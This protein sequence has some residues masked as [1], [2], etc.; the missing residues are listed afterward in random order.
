MASEPTFR[1]RR[2]GWVQ[3]LFLKLP[4]LVYR[5]PLA[6]LLRWRCVMVLTTIGRRSGR[7]R[8]TGISFMPVGERLIV[9][10][11]W[12]VSSNW[13]QNVRAN[14]EVVVQVGRRRM[15]GTARLVE[16]PLQRA[17][18]MLRM[19]ARSGACGPPKLMRP[20][21]T[22]TRVFDYEA[23]IRMAVAQGGDLPVV[24]ITPHT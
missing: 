13:Y 5:G 24:E 17:E 18:L 9:F 16:D 22:L 23:D 12:G 2:A 8:S 11:G 19:Q 10:S 7:P 21:L 15:R 20:V 1:R 14:P 4:P 3:R 6:E